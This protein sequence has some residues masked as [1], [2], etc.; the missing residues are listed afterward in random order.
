MATLKE[1]VREAEAAG[2][3]VQAATAPGRRELADWQAQ[4]LALLVTIG[5]TALFVLA[6]SLLTGT[7]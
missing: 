3:E 4:L 7:L 5:A 1:K 6:F 2:A